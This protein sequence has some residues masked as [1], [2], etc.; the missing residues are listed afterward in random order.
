MS[1][2]FGN[3]EDG[4]AVFD[5]INPVVGYTL[6]GGVYVG[7]RSVA[8]TDAII[9]VGVVVKP[10]NQGGIWVNGTFTNNGLV[11]ANGNKAV[12]GNG[13]ISIAATGFWGSIPGG[14][15]AGFGPGGA[16]IPGL[17]GNGGAGGGVGGVGGLP[18]GGG[19]AGGV[20]TPP[21]VANGGRAFASSLQAGLSG[22]GAAAQAYTSGGGGSGANFSQ[23][24]GGGSAAGCILIAARNIAGS[25]SVTANGGDGGDRTPVPLSNAGGGGGGG[26]GVIWLFTTTA[27]PLTVWTVTV[28]G[29]IGSISPG[30]ATGGGGRN[31]ANG[32]PGT[33][34]APD[35]SI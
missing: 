16:A 17:G 22:K 35:L 27:N 31:G 7:T 30:A 12:G 19:V 25:G 6:G 18:V 8:Y 26:G 10:A 34:Y 5:G 1:M 33:I 20:V 4:P 9:N 15:A 28:N 13:G 29:G 14:G 32:S 2:I 3:G 24:G 21:N 23:G 11:Q